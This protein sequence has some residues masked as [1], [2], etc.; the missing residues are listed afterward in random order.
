[1]VE[2]VAPCAS[3]ESTIETRLDSASSHCKDYVANA[4]HPMIFIQLVLQQVH[5][6]YSV[7]ERDCFISFEC[8]PR[9]Q[10]RAASAELIRPRPP[11]HDDTQ[12]LN[13]CMLER[14]N[15][16]HPNGIIAF[17][18]NI[19]RFFAHKNVVLGVAA[20][21]DISSLAGVSL[22]RVVEPK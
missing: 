22:K 1:M 16:G 19:K 5:L 6:M 20:C 14:E 15:A 18:C 4:E 12:N 21:Q 8:Q 17:L 2:V 10:L 3:E 9:W 13:Q 7:A 11:L